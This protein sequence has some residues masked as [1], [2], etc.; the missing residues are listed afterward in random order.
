MHE[1]RLPWMPPRGTIRPWNG[2]PRDVPR[3]DSRM[4]KENA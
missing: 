3:P 1:E 4:R 2:Y